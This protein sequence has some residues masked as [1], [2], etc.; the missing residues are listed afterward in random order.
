MSVKV[1][2]TFL[3]SSLMGRKCEFTRSTRYRIGRSN[4]C[5]LQLPAT[6]EFMD[7]SRLHCELVIDPP[8]IQVRDLGSRNGTFVNGINVGR[9]R[10]GPSSFAGEDQPGWHVLKEG[11]EL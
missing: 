6:L 7:V 8:A 2:L 3:N 4:E 9:R 5:D 1:T 10:L 11:D